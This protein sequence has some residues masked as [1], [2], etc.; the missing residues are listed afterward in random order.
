MTSAEFLRRAEA[1]HGDDRAELID[2]IV[3]MLPPLSADH[4]TPDSLIS[5]WLT[6]YVAYASGVE[7]FPNTTFIVDQ[8]NTVQPDSILCSVPREGG[9]V[10]F[11]PNKYLC[12][13]PELVCEIATSSVSIDL[14]GKF[15]LYRRTGV[16]E[17]LVWR[18]HENLF[19]WF[20]NEHGNFVAQTPSAAGLLTSRTFPGLVLDVKSLLARHR[21]GVLKALDKGL[22][23][24]AKRKK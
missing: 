20:V 2:G 14:H 5:M 22:A 18:T 3:Y 9:P 24:R 10:W 12:G 11:S 15:H 7:H 21:A 19:D 4:G 8:D 1:W 23:R 6:H 13:S 16:R 17:Y